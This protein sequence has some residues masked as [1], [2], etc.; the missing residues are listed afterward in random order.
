MRGIWLDNQ[1]VT[2]GADGRDPSSSVTTY[3]YPGVTDS[4]YYPTLGE[5]SEIT[6]G[7]TPEDRRALAGIGAFNLAA[8]EVITFDVGYTW[9]QAASGGP[10]A[11]VVE[12]Q[13][14][15]QS[16]RIMYNNGLLLSDSRPIAAHEKTFSVY[17]NPATNFTTIKNLHPGNSYSLLLQDAV[18]RILLKKDNITDE[19]YQVE[20]SNYADGIYF[21]SICQNGNN[22]N[23]KLIIK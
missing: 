21:I 14:A 10:L 20:T 6:A 7:N 18:G 16:L 11:S 12:L 2:Y 8:G 5:W 1:P 3:M 17:P 19:N 4:T 22:F 9:A 13:N 23:Q 15:V